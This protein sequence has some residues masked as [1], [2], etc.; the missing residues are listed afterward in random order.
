MSG[1]IQNTEQKDRL[2]PSRRSLS[3][4]FNM[5]FTGKGKGIESVHKLWSS[6][7][8]TTVK[9]QPLAQKPDPTIHPKELLVFLSGVAIVPE[10]T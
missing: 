10:V 7:L 8:A 2:W 6:E 1:C 3:I 9:R 5:F 4:S